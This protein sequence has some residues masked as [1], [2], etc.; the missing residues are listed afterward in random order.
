MPIVPGS[1]Q[2]YQN[3]AVRNQL[4]DGKK[5]GKCVGGDNES[6]DVRGRGCTLL[7]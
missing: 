7:L 3:G 4:T 6:V 5:G 2:S 1:Y